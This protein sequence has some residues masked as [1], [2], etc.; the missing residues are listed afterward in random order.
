MGQVRSASR[1]IIGF[2]IGISLAA[3][4]G[5]DGGS[6]P[7]TGGQSNNPPPTTGTPPPQTPPPASN[8]SPTIDGQPTSSVLVGQAYDF[9]PSASDSDSD[10]LS[11]SASNLPD[12]ATLDERTGRISGTPGA[13]DIA[14]FSGITITVS[15]GEASSSLGPF[16]IT[17]A[18]VGT[19]SATLSWVPPTQNADG[20]QLTNLAGY[21]IR[22]GR[23]S[24]ELSESVVLT[25][26]S[27]SIY[28]LENL[29]SGTWYFA[30]AALNTEGV[31]SSLSNVASKTIS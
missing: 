16:A 13:E 20:S 27:L 31:T 23:S 1:W 3:C 29:T 2:I 19:G 6:S 21:E 9:R 14:T 24:S 7:E 5:G 22:Y 10:T 30:V 12:W 26:P 15:D 25:N 4:G 8:A 17:V 11:F 18:S 28:V